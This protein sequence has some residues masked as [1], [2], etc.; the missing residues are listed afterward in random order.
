MASDANEIELTGLA[1]LGS[2]RMVCLRVER[3]RQNLT[4]HLGE[5]SGGI[6]VKRID[7]RR[8]TATVEC[9]TN[10]VQLRLVSYCASGPSEASVASA[11]N[12]SNRSVA[13]GTASGHAVAGLG[14]LQ[15][16]PHSSRLPDGTV[17]A[18]TF[19]NGGEGH[20][21]AHL[22]STATDRAAAESG[23]V[24]AV[25]PSGQQLAASP[26]VASA[27]PAGELAQ[28]ENWDSTD[29]LQAER[30]RILAFNGH[31]AFLAWDRAQN[32]RVASTWNR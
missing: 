21:S 19:A 17:V 11:Q 7:F 1:D 30:D 4:L 13:S 14:A 18:G 15:D 23:A 26:D 9:G 28:G 8:K 22:T 6:T 12:P 16:G 10:E 24:P 20:L 5:T 27:F 25:D 2:V 32:F 29:P 31:G 3:G